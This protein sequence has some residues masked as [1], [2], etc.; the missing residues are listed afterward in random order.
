MVI[1]SSLLVICAVNEKKGNIMDLETLNSRFGGDGISFSVGPGNLTV[2]RLEN[3]LGMAELALH[4]GHVMSFVP[5]GGAPVLWMS[6][7]SWF[8]ADK[9]IRGGIPVCWPWFGAHP[10]NA[11]FPSHGFARISEWQ[12]KSAGKTADQVS[13]L[14]LGLTERQVA[15]SFFPQPFD[16]RLR[17]EVSDVLSVALR[18]E[19]TGDEHLN[20]SAALHSYFN[21]SDIGNIAVVGF[22]G[23]PCLDTLDNTRHV[24]SGSLKFERETDLVF[25]DCEEDCFIEDSGLKRRIRI[26]KSGSSSAVVWNPWSDKAG[27][28][29]DFG[30]DEY[31]SM[32]CVE[33]T[34]ALDDARTLA[35]GK[36]HTLGVVI[37]V[38]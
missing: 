37:G 34:N 6:R 38:A 16:L 22:D 24:Q 23:K 30:N 33:T 8:A 35:P 9:P 14:E 26:A 29:P 25:F 31:R 17:V 5:G 11:Q 4:G 12:V 3:E 32:V 27:R 18:I 15:K 36:R 21:I 13:W 2:A 20:F 7:E 1:A 19:N 28:M 10:T